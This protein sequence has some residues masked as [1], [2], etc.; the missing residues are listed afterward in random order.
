MILYFFQ[1]QIRHNLYYINN[2]SVKES[3]EYGSAGWD[4]DQKLISL[5]IHQWMASGSNRNLTHEVPDLGMRR[6]DRNFW[7]PDRILPQFIDKY[8][9]AHMILKVNVDSKHLKKC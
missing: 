4:L 6:I 1:K 8:N 7:I 2:N 9:D 3:V 5:L